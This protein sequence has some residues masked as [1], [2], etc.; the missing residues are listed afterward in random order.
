MFIIQASVHSYKHE[1]AGFKLWKL[2]HLKPRSHQ[3]FNCRKSS[4]GYPRFTDM[5]LLIIDLNHFQDIKFWCE[6]GMKKFN[7]NMKIYDL[8]INKFLRH[9]YENI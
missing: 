9:K 4:M 2:K 5:T 6:Y 3:N 1:T 7:T 8:V